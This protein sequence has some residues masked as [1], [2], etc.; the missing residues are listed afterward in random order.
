MEIKTYSIPN[1]GSFNLILGMS[2]FI[3]TVD[4]LAEIINTMA[5]N[6]K[7]GIAFCEAS[8]EAL[9]R[10]EGN[11]KELIEKAIVIMQNIKA[12][13]IFAIVLKDCFPINILSK[14][15]MCDE[16]V[17]IFSAS[18]NPT[19]VLTIETAG[20]AAVIGVVDGISPRGVENDE[21][22]KVRRDFLKKIGYKF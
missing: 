3:K 9:I 6:A 15:K 17:R 22:K 14:I 4:D 2:H 8:G 1:D 11:D 21:D 10:H 20:G 7:Y 19:S 5:S 12:G 16:V 13:H 18:A